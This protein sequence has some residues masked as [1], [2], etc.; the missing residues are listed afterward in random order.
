MRRCLIFFATT[1]GLMALVADGLLISPLFRTAGA[2]R[3]EAQLSAAAQ[4]QI[5]AL[6]DEKKSRTPTQK[7]IDS[8]LLFAM[9]ARRGEPMTTGGEVRSLRSAVEIAKN[10]ENGR[11]LVDIKADV[12][13]ELI[14]IIERLGGEITY[15]S[16]KARAVR[17]RVPF[18]SLEELASVQAVRSIRP[19]AKA[20]THRQLTSAS[21]TGPNPTASPTRIA[22]PLQAGIRH[23]L[24]RRAMNVRTQL[25]A[26]L[27]R[28]RGI[29]FR[30]GCQI[31][32][33]IRGNFRLVGSIGITDP[34]RPDELITVDHGYRQTRDIR[35]N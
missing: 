34:F 25:S 2:Q 23:D 12:N 17:A 4:G 18:E 9:K 16:D 14:V 35:L 26:A 3:G 28:A 29:C 22:H 24:D 13:K 33:C 32:H 19:A 7:K 1:L 10:D 6:L 15:A 5:K 31:E 30:D 27:A 8:Q 20:I 11:V 21:R